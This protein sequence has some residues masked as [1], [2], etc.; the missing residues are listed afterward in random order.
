MLRRP[1]IL[2]ALAA[3]A[4]PVALTGVSTGGPPAVASPPSA[5]S[6]ASAYRAAATKYGV[7]ESVLLA[8][9]YAE[10]VGRLRPDAPHRSRCV[11]GCRPVRQAEGRHGRLAADAEEGVRV[12]RA[13]P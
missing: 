11:G 6:A 12:D 13:G 10:H 8:V 1:K 5:S 4:L 3:V 2:A 7:P 9:S